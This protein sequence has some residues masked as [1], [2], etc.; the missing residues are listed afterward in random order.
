MTGLYESRFPD[1]IM[2]RRLYSMV[3]V[4]SGSCLLRACHVEFQT[5]DRKPGERAGISP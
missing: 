2:R 5:Q 4:G 1:L 3:R